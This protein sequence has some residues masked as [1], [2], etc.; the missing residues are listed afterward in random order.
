MIL[1][2]ISRRIVGNDP[3]NISPSN[4]F[5]TMLLPAR[6]NKNCQAAFGCCKCLWDKV[7]EFDSHYVVLYNSLHEYR[8]H[9]SDSCLHCSK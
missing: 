4:I 1:Q 7:I 5:F 2:N 3:V 8:V 6:M 9:H